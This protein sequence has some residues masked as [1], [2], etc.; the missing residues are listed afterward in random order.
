[1]NVRTLPKPKRVGTNAK[2]AGSFGSKPP[3]AKR[4]LVLALDAIC[5]EITALS[6]GG[7]CALCGMAGVHPHHFFGKKAFPSLRWVPDNLIWLCFYDHAETVHTKGETGPLREILM[8]KIGI[9]RLKALE[10]MA[11]HTE[12]RYLYDLNEL[13]KELSMRLETMRQLRS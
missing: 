9:D 5:S 13:K 11:C 3:S 12:K 2:R 7:R 8:D 10:A 6:W 1:M 4:R